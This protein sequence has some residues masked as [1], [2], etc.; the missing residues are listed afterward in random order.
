MYSS[1]ALAVFFSIAALS[2]LA[3][4]HSDLYSK[5]RMSLEIDI[6][7]EAAEVR[8]APRHFKEKMHGWSLDD[9]AHE[10][11]QRI[12]AYPDEKI[13]IKKFQK[14]VRD[15]F[16]TFRDY[17]VNVFFY[18]TEEASLPLKVKGIQGKYYISYID[19]KK[20]SPAHCPF[21]IG[22][23][24]ILFGVRPTHE[25]V[26]ELKA[27]ELPKIHEATDEALA[28]SLLTHRYGMRGHRIPRGPISLTV[29]S[30]ATGQNLSYQLIWDYTPE[31]I[32]HACLMPPC[33]SVFSPM[34]AEPLAPLCSDLG[35][36]KSFL[37][38]LGNV[39]WE[40]PEESAFHAYLFEGPDGELYGYVRIPH[41]NGG[42][43]EI[44]HFSAIVE[45]FEANTRALVIDQLQNPGGSLFFL[46][47]LASMLTDQPLKTPL[48]RLSLTH[49]E[50]T[51]AATM[52]PL[53]LAVN[54][55]S[56]AE[57]VLSKC[58]NFLQGNTPTY[59]MA[60]FFLH[61]LYFIQDQ[62]QRGY[63][64]TEPF[65]L[66]GIDQINP[67]SKVRYTKPIL[68]LIDS[69]DFSGGDFFPAIFQDNGRALL[70]GERTAGA[71]G[72]FIRTSHLNPFGI[73]CYSLTTSLAE[74]PGELIIE[75]NGVQPDIPYSL[76]V[77]DLQHNYEEFR[78]KILELC[79][80]RNEGLYY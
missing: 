14:I 28:A 22:D 49:Q 76:T 51:L 55:E 80:R 71:G 45:L 5:K 27:S 50:A 70:L 68:I 6:L 65:Y 3:E 46:Y 75:N 31:K 39:A 54:T 42:M 4:D 63:R 37:P 59:Q 36:R 41:Y 60:Q 34:A 29:L 67:H 56:E 44:Q 79:M 11:Q 48:H 35:R 47:A 78:E 8:Y 13:P 21:S 77:R 38:P 25:C 24:L 33:G 9:S 15:F 53:L 58:K 57:A 32:S 74:R 23:E 26:A 73:R 18:S 30:K 43:R 40:T 10:A 16:F 17:H 66:C 72:A 62:W 69:L 19:E 52:I 1:K 64:L 2:L 7:K 61:Y 12:A 20:L